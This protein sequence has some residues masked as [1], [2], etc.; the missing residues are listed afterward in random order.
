[1]PVPRSRPE[2]AR[3]AR[4]SIATVR[5]GGHRRWA[6]F[7][8]TVNPLTKALLRSP[9]H[10]LRS[11]KLALIT[12]TGRRSGREFTFPVSYEQAGDRVSITVGFAEQKLW[13]RNLTGGGAAVRIRLGGQEHGGHAVAR[14]E[15]ASG[16]TVVIDL[17]PLRT[18]D[19]V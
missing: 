9:L 12:V 6:I 8:H 10:R 3:Q 4:C 2:P 17:D 13:W 18:L 1:M 19:G 5:A 16:V 11:D 15:P 14:G 7:N